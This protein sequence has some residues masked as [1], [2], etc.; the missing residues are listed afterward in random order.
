M[1]RIKIEKDKITLLLNKQRSKVRIADSEG[2]HASSPTKCKNESKYFVEW[3]IT[4]ENVKDIFKILKMDEDSLTKISKG[5]KEDFFI[6][7]SPYS[8][9]EKVKSTFQELCL[10][11]DF[12]IYEYEEKFYSFE[13]E[14]PSKIRIRITYKKGDLSIDPVPYMFVLIPFDDELIKIK[15]ADGLVSKGGLLGSKCKCEWAPSK[16]DLIEIVIGLSKTSKE[17][18][19]ALI[20]EL[21]FDFK[22]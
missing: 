1:E 8:K 5:F 19:K 20:K 21:D 18:R 10:F 16:K 3:M 2:N 9:R 6:E 12:K 22:I 17:H 7:D 13:K 11:E 14:L 15:N 4:N